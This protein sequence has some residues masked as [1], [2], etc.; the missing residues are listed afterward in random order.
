MENLLKV[1]TASHYEAFAE[2][3][4][5]LGEWE[6]EQAETIFKYLWSSPPVP[7]S[8]GVDNMRACMYNNAPSVSFDVSGFQYSGEVIVSY[9]EGADYYRVYFKHGNEYKLTFDDVCFA[10]L[11][12]LIDGEI[13]TE[14]GNGEDYENKVNNYVDTLPPEVQMLTNIMFDR[15]TEKK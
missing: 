11:V 14:D 2:T 8:W 15:N 7:M 12:S 1:I 9:N 3:L 13:E 10:D 5:S 6:R 4:G